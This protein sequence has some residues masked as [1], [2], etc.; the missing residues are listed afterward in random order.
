MCSY[1]FAN[2]TVMSFSQTDSFRAR[3]AAAIVAN[4]TITPLTCPSYL[5][6]ETQPAMAPQWLIGK[7][8]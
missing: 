4:T 7:F 5:A 8:N 3:L 6:Q 2:S 1:R